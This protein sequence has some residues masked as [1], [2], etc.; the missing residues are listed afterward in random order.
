MQLLA[1]GTAAWKFMFVI[2]LGPET[3]KRA[4]ILTTPGL[5]ADT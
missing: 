1:L 3:W 2:E 4:K 5:A